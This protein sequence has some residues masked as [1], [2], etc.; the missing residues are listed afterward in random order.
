MQMGNVIVLAVWL[1]R[2][3]WFSMSIGSGDLIWGCGSC[4]FDQIL[5]IVAFLSFDI[6]VVWV[7]EPEHNLC[8][9]GW[10]VVVAV[11]LIVYVHGNRR[12]DLRTCFMLFWTNIENV[13]FSLGIEVV[14]VCEPDTWWCAD[15]CVIFLNLIV[16][17]WNYAWL[18]IDTI[19]PWVCTV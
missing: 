13:W 12:L 4:C 6:E 5:R 7:W 11:I 8:S 2:W 14:L 9:C 1:L 10:Y 17:K 15:V 19:V 18:Y 16:F 3:L